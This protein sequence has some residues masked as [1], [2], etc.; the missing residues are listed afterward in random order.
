VWREVHANVTRNHD[1]RTMEQL[2]SEVV[3]HLM[4]RN[5]AAKKTWLRCA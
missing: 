2:M 5:R 3:Y 4:S 1:C